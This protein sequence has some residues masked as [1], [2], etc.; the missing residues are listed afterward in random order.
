MKATERPT[1]YHLWLLG[2]LANGHGMMALWGFFVLCRKSADS[3]HQLAD[4]NQQ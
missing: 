1:F 4:E 2:L 3:R